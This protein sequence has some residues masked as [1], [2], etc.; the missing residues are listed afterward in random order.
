LPHKSQIA[1]LVS[2][3]LIA[4]LAEDWHAEPGGRMFVAGS[5]IA[6][7]LDTLKKDPL[8]LKPAVV[9]T[10]TATEYAEGV[11]ATRNHLLLT[12]LDNVQGRVYVYTRGPGGVWTKKKLA[13]PENRAVAVV[14]TNWSD[15]Q[16]FIRTTGFLTPTSLLLAN[17]DTGVLK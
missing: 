1:A 7:D 5:V 13:T 16:F 14:T 9:F 11:E 17:G 10:P 3:Q 6:L 8:H 12:T 2:N 15:N 4:T